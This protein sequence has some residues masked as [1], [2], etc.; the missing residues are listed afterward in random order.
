MDHV[1]IRNFQSLRQVD[2]DL[3]KLTVIVGSSSSGKSALV[4]A[5]RALTSNVRG[6]DY[7]SVGQRSAAISVRLGD[8]GVSLQRGEGV[9]KY[10]IRTENERGDELAEVF[11]K[12]AGGVPELVTKALNIP[13]DSTLN[14][15]GQFDPPYLL[16]DSGAAVARTL[17][18]LTNVSTILEAVREANRR[19]LAA[20]SA[21]KLRRADLA[22]LKEKAQRYAGLPRKLQLCGEAEK[23]L[24]EVAETQARLDHLRSLLADQIVARDVLARSPVHT[25]PTYQPVA[26]AHDRLSLLTAL[27]TRQTAARHAWEQA[28]T[29]VAQAE[30][31]ETAWHRRLHE[32]LVAAGVCP[33]CGSVITE[34]AHV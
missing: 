23:A 12:L 20:S 31:V 30:Q 6:S 28:A 13:P 3:G 9:G 4:R 19:R 33:T 27:R 34:D 15:A 22:V 7:V 14:F 16:T 8:T 32:V 26:T 18:E 2:L 21:L 29:T 11:T 10:E 5:L 1:S 25:L 24:V 17:G